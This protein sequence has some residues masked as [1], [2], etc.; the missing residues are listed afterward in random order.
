MIDFSDTRVHG[1][2]SQFNVDVRYPWDQA[3]TFN[4]WV[5]GA[6]MQLKLRG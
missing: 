5:N 1:N 6:T 2:H 3:E 4:Q